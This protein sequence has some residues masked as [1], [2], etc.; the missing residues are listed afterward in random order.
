MIR[1][2]IY[3]FIFM[4]PL[5]AQ[6]ITVLSYNIWN[7]FDWSKDTVRHDKTVAWIKSQN[8]HVVA[9]QELCGY[10]EDK[11]KTDAKE[12]G[13]KYSIL[14]KTDGYPVGLTSKRPIQLKEKVRDGMWHG[15][16]HGETFGVDF[17]VV[18]LSPSDVNFRIK[19]ADIIRK[20]VQNISNERFILLGD[21]NALS[22]Q[23]REAMKTKTTLLNQHR[24]S[25]KSNKKGHSNLRNDAFDFSVMAKFQAL[26][27]VDVCYPLMK[28]TDRFS[29]PTP[30]LLGKYHYKQKQDIQTYSR[31]IDYILTSPSLAKLC[32][33][34]NIYNGENT[35]LL[36]DHYPVMAKFE[37]Q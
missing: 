22:T 24:E 36:S 21:F 5:M 9:L 2:F 19:E 1:R 11:L 35:G 27:T 7:G 16:L 18:H 3:I 23:D 6:S 13:H 33:A 32:T 25:A 37:L 12:W 8:P 26:P 28:S 34:A 17:F 4:V 15:M 20:K 29:F 14:L 31:R 10:T 30:A